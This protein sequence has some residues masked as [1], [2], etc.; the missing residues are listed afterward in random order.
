MERP[1]YGGSGG[2]L[3]PKLFPRCR[4]TG[5][6]GSPATSN[7]RSASR[8]ASFN[9]EGRVVASIRRRNE[10]QLF[11]GEISDCDECPGNRA[12]RKRQPDA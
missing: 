10:R 9:N 11:C 1:C 2:D 7:A 8:S 12:A 3:A 5:R 6:F 4:Y